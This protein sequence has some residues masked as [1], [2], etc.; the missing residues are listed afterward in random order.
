MRARSTRHPGPWRSTSSCPPGNAPGHR[1]R[2]LARNLAAR[3]IGNVVDLTGDRTKGSHH[4]AVE[5]GHEPHV[6]AHAEHLM[7][8]HS[9]DH[10]PAGS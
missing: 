7:Q 8:A 9:H 4:P 5:H 1:R 6:D 10:A 3:G 2:E